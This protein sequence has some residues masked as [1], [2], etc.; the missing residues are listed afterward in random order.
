MGKGTWRI[1]VGPDGPSRTEA[2]SNQKEGLRVS[3][4]TRACG[5]VRALSDRR[6]PNPS[7]VREPGCGADGGRRRPQRGAA[8][9][10]WE[11]SLVSQEERGVYSF[12]IVGSRV[13][14][15]RGSA[16]PLTRMEEALRPAPVR[17]CRHHLF[18]LNPLKS[19]S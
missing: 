18:L 6:E 12:K 2:C 5:G 13:C 11:A 10:V 1:V 8:E 15:E 14:E 16:V 7:Q 17:L 9:R 3:N 4:S 19:N